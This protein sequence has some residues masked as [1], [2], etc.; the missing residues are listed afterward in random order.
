M[1][2]E[3]PTPTRTRVNYYELMKF[4]MNQKL[5]YEGQLCTVVGWSTNGDGD[6]NTGV[7][8]SYK[9]K[10]DKLA[11][12]VQEKDLL[13]AVA[14]ITDSSATIEEAPVAP[15]ATIEESPVAPSATSDDVLTAS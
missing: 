2:E 11:N 7:G 14:K 12:F 6:R 1:S 15:S 8:T 3:T 4:K 10:L 5:Q 9:Y 13:A